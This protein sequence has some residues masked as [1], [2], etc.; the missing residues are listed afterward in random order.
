MGL[1]W[2]LIKTYQIKVTVEGISTK[3]AMLAWVNSLVPEYSIVNFNTNWND[4]RAVCGVVDHIRPGACPNHL[5]LK[6]ANGLENCQLGMDLAER[7][8]GIPKVIDPADLNNPDVDELSV[9]TY[10]SYFCSPAN[11]LLIDWIRKKI[12]ERNI[13]N[14][15]TDWNNGIN[16]GALGEACFAG[17]CPEVDDLEPT[18]A[19]Q[20]NEHLL[21]LMKDRLGLQCPISAAEIAD[22]KIDELIVATYLSQFR[23]AKLKATP[24]EF[25]FRVPTLPK[26]AALVKEPV[27]FE[28]ELTE[29]TANLKDDIRVSAHGPSADVKVNLKPK[30]KY[31]LEATL[32]PTEAG[33][34]DVMAM[35]HDE[36]IAGS[37]FSLPVADPSKCS[38]FGDLPSD[39]QVGKEDTF[40]VKAREAGLAKLTCTFGDKGAQQS[41][42][43][44]DGEITEQENQQYDVK[45]VPK[46]IGSIPVHLKWASVDIPRTP[47]TVNVCD[48]RKV[49]ISGIGSEGRAGEPVSFTVVAKESE[50]GRGKL[51]VV[52]R[53]PSANY[54]PDIRNNGD[55]SYVVT[56]IP[57][58]VGPHKIGVEYGG[59][60]VPKSPVSMSIVAAPDANTCSVAGKGLKRAVAEE[61]TS[62]QIL[63]PESGLLT[64]KDPVGLQVSTVGLLEQKKV[65]AA[66]E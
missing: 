55:G 65:V 17:I 53:G 7:L 32:V 11:Q 23:N 64:K 27:T 31:G 20:N 19:I 28:V 46:K 63:S 50:C 35:Y 48:A 5:A 14:L 49:S 61:K 45:L 59:G 43:I 38:V 25:G 33:S 1:I 51:N 3:K 57:W 47:F 52:P 24:E 54:N 56:F 21:G 39:M 18:N 10:M 36:N 42:P 26:G 44:L 8:L 58:E 4:G 66:H 41:T 37:P 40:A 34:Y 6:P 30:G 12:P 62:F 2:T 9:M 22:P 60:K 29:Q 16:L 13:K 15:S